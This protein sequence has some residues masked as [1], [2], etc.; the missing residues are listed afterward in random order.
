MAETR[1]SDRGFASVGGLPR[2]MNQEQESVITTCSH[3][4]PPP[5][6]YPPPASAMTLPLECESAGDG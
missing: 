5:R 2:M 4:G 6:E 3:Q 1:E